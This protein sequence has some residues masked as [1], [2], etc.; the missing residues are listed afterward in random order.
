[1]LP[2]ERVEN[3]PIVVAYAFLVPALQA[4][5]GRSLSFADLPCLCSVPGQDYIVRLL[6]KRENKGWTLG[7][8]CRMTYIAV[9]CVGCDYPG[10]GNVDTTICLDATACPYLSNKQ[11]KSHSYDNGE[12]RVKVVIWSRQQSCSGLVWLSIYLLFN[13]LN[14]HIGPF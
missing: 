5:T 7:A 9:L 8:E 4:E 3:L 14:S 10:Q 11:N 12:D 1:M 13:L 2:V 6:L